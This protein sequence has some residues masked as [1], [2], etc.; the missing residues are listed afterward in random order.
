METT[1]SDLVPTTVLVEDSLPSNGLASVTSPKS[2]IA[3]DTVL[4][5]SAAIVHVPTPGLAW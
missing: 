2:L 4:P 3:M 1:G 5:G